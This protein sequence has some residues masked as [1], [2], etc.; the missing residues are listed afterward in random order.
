MSQS[1][2]HDLAFLHTAQSHV[3]RFDTLLHTLA[4]HLRIR[5][6]VRPDLL[7]QAQQSERTNSELIANVQRALQEAAD[8]GAAVVVCTCS[9]IGGMAEA[10]NSET[11]FTCQRIDRA[12]ADAAV[13]AGPRILV[14]L[15][16]ASS[17]APTLEL[18][19]QLAN[20]NG[21]VIQAIPLE[22]PQAWA[23]FLQH[24]LSNYHATLAAAVRT[25]PANYD[26]VVLAQASMQELAPTLADI[27]KPV[28]CSPHLG[29][30]KAL[31][32]LQ[33]SWPNI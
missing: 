15:A 17:K 28:L 14:V 31:A 27:G 24:D 2:Q 16:L 12:M 32:E 7:I 13:K 11:K 3:E 22:L 4:P 9:S 18:L 10:L 1:T 29:V 20:A 26:V 6:V 23:Y 30:L 33:P 8:S 19:Q 21:R 25:H 5:H